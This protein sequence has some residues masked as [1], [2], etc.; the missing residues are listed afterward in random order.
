M[1]YWHDKVVL[2]TGASAGLGRAIAAA[3]A[4]QGAR[5]ALCA[6][7]AQRLI[8]VA[9]ELGAH[10]GNV[11]SIPADVTRQ[12]EVAALVLRT[13][14]KFGRIDV[15]VN[16]VGRSTR[17]KALDVS[18]DEYR[19]LMELNFLSAVHATRAAAPHLLATQGH[20]VN[21]GS[22]AAKSAARFLGGYPA[23]KFALA[24]YSQQLRLELAPLGVHVLLV[25]PG[26]LERD[27][28]GKRY[29]QQAAGL[30]E[31][32][33]RPGGGAKVRLIRPEDLARRILSA[34]ERRQPELVVPGKARWLFAMTQLW[35]A[36]GDRILLRMTR[37]EDAN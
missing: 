23:S 32:A 22:L 5:L 13:V 12:D 7:D 24:A 11:V 37:S 29:A 28:A 15:L 9:S 3:F 8:A 6:R 36:L 25:C 26:P 10:G 17:G 14:E 35:P 31:S 33:S 4:A 20:I 34:C 1:S 27:D 21:I 16:N 18:P 19:Q 2:V 30:P